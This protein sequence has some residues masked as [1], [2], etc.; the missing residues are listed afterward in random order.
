MTLTNIFLPNL[1]AVIYLGHHDGVNSKDLETARIVMSGA[2]PLGAL[3]V[4]RFYAKY[5]SILLLLH[6]S[7]SQFNS[8][9][10]VLV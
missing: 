10:F 7:R 3:D 5:E 4:E 6:P 9:F 2:A 1:I 8:I